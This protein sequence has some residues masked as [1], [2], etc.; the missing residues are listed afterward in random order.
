[1]IEEVVHQLSAMKEGLLEVVPKSSL[2]GLTVED[3]QLT[4]ALTLTPYKVSP[5]RTSSCSWLGSQA[6]LM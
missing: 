3:F 1:M 2:Q 4:L 6:V 5:R